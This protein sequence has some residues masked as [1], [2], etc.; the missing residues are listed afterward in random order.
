[1]ILRYAPMVV[2]LAVNACASHAQPVNPPSAESRALDSLSVVTAIEHG[3]RTAHPRGDV[4]LVC[5]SVA[6]ADPD[7]ALLASLQASAV[8]ARRPASACH[9]DTTGSRRTSRSLVAARAGGDL[10]GISVNAGRRSVVDDSTV[11]FMVSYYQHYVS[12]ADWRCK[13]RRRGGQWVTYMCQME[14][15]S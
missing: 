8:I 10:R 1:M 6:S 2:T 15:I 7:P 12:G 11:M 5:V 3:L 13:A 4:R 14:R 9:V